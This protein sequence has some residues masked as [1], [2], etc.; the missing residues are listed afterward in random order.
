M[1]IHCLENHLLKIFSLNNLER[2]NVD[3]LKK[4]FLESLAFIKTLNDNM[5]NNKD[6]NKIQSFKQFTAI[7]FFKVYFHLYLEILISNKNVSQCI[8]INDYL[9]DNQKNIVVKIIEFYILKIIRNRYCN[10][11]EDF[12]NFNFSNFQ[13]LWVADLKFKGEFH[14][15]YEY[16]FFSYWDDSSN[17]QNESCNY[18]EIYDNFIS[19]VFLPL[20]EKVFRTSEYDIEILNFIQEYFDMWID[21]IMN[22]MLCETYTEEYL[23]KQVFVE[24]TSWAKFLINELNCDEKLIYLFQHLCI[25]NNFYSKIL[26]SIKTA[27]NGD[28]IN[29]NDLEIIFISLK[30]WLALNLNEGGFQ[31]TQKY[32]NDNLNEKSQLSYILFQYISLSLINFPQFSETKE[33][34]NMY[35]KISY[36]LRINN[37]NQIKLFMNFLYYRIKSNISYISTDILFQIINKAIDD[38]PH[39]KGFIEQYYTYVKY[40]KETIRNLLLE[41]R[42]IPQAMNGNICQINQGLNPKINIPVFTYFYYE[43]LPSWSHFIQMHQ[44]L[45]TNKYPYISFFVDK[46]NYSLYGEHLTSPIIK[47]IVSLNNNVKENQE[48]I[49]FKYSRFSSLDELAVYYS[50]SAVFRGKEPN[51]N[52]GYLLEYD[53]EAIEQELATIELSF[54]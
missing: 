5:I 30:F 48:F 18:F 13:L 28:T 14:T 31:I 24:F 11:F 19:T 38:W 41:E 27:K 51:L 52:L 40:D 3:N 43:Q 44:N 17:K 33:L 2:L 46:R 37:I 50:K 22:I 45:P 16:I 1:L 34:L 29:I 54:K 7:S 53:V 15:N 8:Y 6:E 25:Y 20:K 39:Q 49:D 47:R 21:V 4:M 23:M 26:D 10:S 9:M 32:Q 35:H 42:I 36:L 12:R